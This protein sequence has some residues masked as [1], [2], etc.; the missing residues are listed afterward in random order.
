[1]SKTAAKNASKGKAIAFIKP[2]LATL[3]DDAPV[4]GGWISETKYDGYR[5][6]AHVGKSETILF[7]R[8]ALDWSHKFSGI[9]TAINSAV[10]NRH[11]VLDGEIVVNTKGQASFHAL[12]SAL[13]EK[14]TTKA[15]YMV[16][17]ILFYDGIDLR[18]HPLSERRKLLEALLK[19]FPAKS[20]VQ[21]SKVLRGVASVSLSK[22]CAVGG[23]GII[24]K[25]TDAPYTSGRGNGWVKVKCGKR[26]EF[27]VVGYSE[28]KGSREGVGALLL[29]V[30]E[31]GKTLHYSG[32]VGSG[33]S[34]SELLTLRK[35]LAKIET[36]KSPLTAGDNAAAVRESGKVQWVQ[37]KLVAEISFTEWTSDGLLRHPV[38]QGLRDDKKPTAVKRE[39][40]TK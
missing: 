34:S 21:I 38:F 27:V 12:Q 37:P 35:T 9:V 24:C 13:G 10:N 36:E 18:G 33:F 8:N 3:V 29:G 16:F 31:R 6:Q 23:E 17:D 30:Y 28:P 26:Q 11:T 7:S 39:G 32:R 14:S 4:G 20:N 15:K 1:M 5:M 40:A 25:K 22:V 2:Q 19:T